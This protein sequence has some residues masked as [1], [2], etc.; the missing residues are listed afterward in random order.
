MR[1]KGSG[2]IHR[3]VPDNIER[4]HVLQAM[5]VIDRDGV[6]SHR[7]S[8]LYEVLHGGKRYPPKYLISVAHT[9]IDGSE[10]PPSAFF[11]GSQ[12]NNFLI[13]RRFDIVD[14]GGRPVKLRP[15][16]EDDELDFPEGRRRYALHRRLERNP[17]VSRVAKEKRL[18]ETGHLKCDACDFSFSKRYGPRG[19]GFIEAHHTA[20]VSELRR[21]ARTRLSNI[22]LVCSNCHRM[23]HRRR[24]W[25]R[26]DQL[27]MLLQ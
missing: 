16:E 20:P 12:T 11:G 5:K 19:H 21:G 13:A 24:P 15:I 23:L 10:W 4:S 14:K 8:T 26:M 7:R 9:F 18:S 27:R 3:G 17:Q 2:S 22:A 1:R 25:L 6:P